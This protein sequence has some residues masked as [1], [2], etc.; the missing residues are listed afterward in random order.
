[1]AP[2]QN[3]NDYRKIQ[4]AI[5]RVGSQSVATANILAGKYEDGSKVAPKGKLRKP[6]GPAKLKPMPKA[7]KPARKRK[8]K[9]A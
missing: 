5:K 7:V 6:I 1:M 8:R 4:R 9:A 3:F 2:K